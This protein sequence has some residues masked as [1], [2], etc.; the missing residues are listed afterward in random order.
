M[1]AAMVTNAVRAAVLA[2]ARAEMNET[3]MP[4]MRR[5]PTKP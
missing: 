5:M 3:E 2:S 1:D 4:Q